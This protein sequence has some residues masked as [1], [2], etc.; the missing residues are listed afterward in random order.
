MD[1]KL[2]RF[3]LI[4]MRTANF[5]SVKDIITKFE[6]IGQ[7]SKRT[8]L[9]SKQKLFRNEIKI[10]VKKFKEIQRSASFLPINAE[11]KGKKENGF[12]LIDNPTSELTESDA[13]FELYSIDNLENQESSTDTSPESIVSAKSWPAEKESRSKLRIR[14]SDI[15]VLNEDEVSL[16]ENSEGEEKNLDL[17][18]SSKSF[19]YKSFQNDSN[20]NLA[21]DNSQELAENVTNLP[22]DNQNSPEIEDHSPENEVLSMN[23]LYTNDESLLS[24]DEEAKVLIGSFDE[25]M[26]SEICDLKFNSSIQEPSTSKLTQ[27]E[28]NHFIELERALDDLDKGVDLLLIAKNDSKLWKKD[29]S[30]VKEEDETHEGED[31]NT[32]VVRYTG[33]TFGNCDIKT[34]LIELPSLKTPPLYDS[35]EDSTDGS[36]LNNSHD[37][38]VQR[39]DNFYNVVTN[40]NLA[41]KS[42]KKKRNKSSCFGRVFKKK[43]KY[44]F[45]DDLNN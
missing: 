1:L 27:D 26:S 8:S 10:N 6:K 17:T 13:Q 38:R 18:S 25:S 39:D 30:Q 20:H 31:K 28:Q 35:F 23:N 29:L 44:V 37:D 19:D 43:K 9:R 32:S 36:N 21:E 42:S 2:I 11:L 45:D 7:E 34:V 33:D 4:F 15:I 40:K 3:L 12:N 24:A 14:F 22:N 5:S 41:K 16:F